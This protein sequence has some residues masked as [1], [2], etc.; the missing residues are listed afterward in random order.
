MLIL[1]DISACWWRDKESQE[2]WCTVNIPNFV[3]IYNLSMVTRRT[4][5]KYSAD[6]LNGMNWRTHNALDN[7]C[8]TAGPSRE[9]KQPTVYL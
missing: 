2:V 9:E 8:K 4:H 6:G 5:T 1:A 7:Y 3:V